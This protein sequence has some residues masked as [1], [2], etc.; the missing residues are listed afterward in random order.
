MA[1]FMISEGIPVYNIDIEKRIL[2][3]RF[4]DRPISSLNHSEK[5]FYN[6]V[7]MFSEFI[8]TGD[9]RIS[10]EWSGTFMLLK[11]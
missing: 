6:S 9:I 10:R 11:V 5:E 8:L 3:D 2:H 1:R 4:K 7:K